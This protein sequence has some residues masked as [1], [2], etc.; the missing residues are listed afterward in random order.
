M[1]TPSWLTPHL[2]KPGQS[3]N[4]HGLG[5]AVKTLAAQIR[6]ESGNGAEIMEFFFAV[7]RGEPVR[8]GKRGPMRTPKFEHR[9]AAAVWLADRGWGKARELIELS[10]D[11]STH[12]E[13]LELLRRLSDEDRA[14]IR[15][16]LERALSHI[17]GQAPDG[18]RATRDAPSPS[19]SEQTDKY[20]PAH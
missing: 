1:S 2:W 11:A 17:D 9:L 5:S 8:F 10:R 15:A 13:R 20:L 19:P 16:V 4:P 12:P 14:T 6:R 3:G 7:M 18:A